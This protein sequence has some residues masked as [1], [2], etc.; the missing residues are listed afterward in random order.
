MPQYTYTTTVKIE[1]TVNADEEML[2][3]TRAYKLFDEIEFDE[4]PSWKEDEDIHLVWQANLTLEPNT[5]QP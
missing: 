1:I 2:A 3:R 4:L 5:S